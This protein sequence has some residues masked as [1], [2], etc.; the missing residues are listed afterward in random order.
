M[1]AQIKEWQDQS[2]IVLR[3]IET[4]LSAIS[5][6]IGTLSGTVNQLQND[7]AKPGGSLGSIADT[8]Q[9]LS[10]ELVRL[11]TA[12]KEHMSGHVGVLSES[13]VGRGGFWKGIWMVIG[14]Q[15]AGWVV[16][17]IY[18][19]KKDTGKKFI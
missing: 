1:T 19:S 9:R 10:D 13:L 8:L 14:V 12:L 4:S 18:R 6:S 16:Y 15:T 2:D 11:E 17:E 5:R 3:R 7:I